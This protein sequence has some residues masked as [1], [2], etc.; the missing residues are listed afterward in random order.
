MFVIRHI[1][2]VS[3]NISCFCDANIL[4]LLET[5]PFLGMKMFLCDCFSLGCHRLDLGGG[6]CTKLVGLHFTAQ[7]MKI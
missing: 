2:P 1:L 6:D 4:W 5:A 3:R 7:E